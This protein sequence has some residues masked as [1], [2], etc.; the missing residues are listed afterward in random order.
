MIQEALNVFNIPYI[1]IGKKDAGNYTVYT[2]RATAAGAT[3]SRLRS[4]LEDIKSYTGLNISIQPDAA[5]VLLRVEHENKNIYLFKDY[6]GYLNDSGYKLP[7]M[8]GLT[9]KG[10]IVEDLTKCPHILIAGTTGSGKSSY[11]HTL[12]MSLFDRCNYEPLNLFLVDCKRVEFSIYKNHCN[13]FFD[14]K[15]ARDCITFLIE[16]IERRYNAMQRAGVNT[17]DDF[18]RLNP[19]YRYYILIIDELADLI[20]TKQAQKTIIPDLLRIAQ[21]GR[22]AGVHMVLATQRPDTSIING[23]LKGNIPTRISFNVATRFDSQVI[24]DR[25]G[26]EYL[27]GNGDGLYLKNEARDLLRFQSTYIDMDTLQ[28]IFK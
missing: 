25:G 28:N 10:F 21:I 12:I 18:K 15:G 20:S 5:G 8:I 7:F 19:E 1:I 22:A 2:L 26:A 9:Q 17:F 16:E 11:L 14:T 27:T 3:L 24:I 6:N 4:R 13:V 23:T